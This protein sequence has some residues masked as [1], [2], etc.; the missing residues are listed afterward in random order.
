MMLDDVMGGKSTGELIVD[1]A[2]RF[3]GYLNTHG[4][5]FV[6]IA[7]RMELNLERYAGIVV[8]MDAGPEPRV[9]ELQLED[10]SGVS[11]GAP[12]AV[13]MGCGRASVFVPLADFVRA[14]DARRREV[15]G[16][17]LDPRTVQE[18]SVYLL[19]QEG[20]YSLV[21][22]D[23]TAVADEQQSILPQPYSGSPYDPAV[24]AR[25]AISVGA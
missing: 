1:E 2:I 17:S 21:V 6:S 14:S 19:F 13:P 15:S 23:V 20:D 7:R 9:W 22:Y 8:T 10:D 4:G 16:V 25:A 12:L 3:S 24:L 18:V 11:F 5:G